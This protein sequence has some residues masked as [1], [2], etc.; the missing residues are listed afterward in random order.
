[1]KQSCRV[2]DYIIKTSIPDNVQLLNALLG[3]SHIKEEVGQQQ[4]PEMSQLEA[5]SRARVVNKKALEITLVSS[6][7]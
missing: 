5:L 2:P 1:M 3:F 6:T 4:Y 7:M